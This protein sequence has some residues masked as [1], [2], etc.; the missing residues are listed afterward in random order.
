MPTG[1]DANQSI[2]TR[3]CPRPPLCHALH[4]RLRPSISH[5]MLRRGLAWLFDFLLR[6]RMAAQAKCCGSGEER[7]RVRGRGAQG[8]ERGLPLDQISVRAVWNSRAD[9]TSRIWGVPACRGHLS[10]GSWIP[11]WCIPNR[12]DARRCIWFSCVGR[13]R[14]PRMVSVRVNRVQ[15]SGQTFAIRR[16]QP[17][18]L[19]GCEV[20]GWG[21]DGAASCMPVEVEVAE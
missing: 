13:N 19:C 6:V 9:D 15:W 7:L 4:C 17:R 2:S 12:R 5:G 18:D 3:P 20:V 1:W 8:V 16:F 14:R 10:S 21:V 11:R